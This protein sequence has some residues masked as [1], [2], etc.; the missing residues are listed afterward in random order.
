MAEVTIDHVPPR[1]RDLF[2]KGFIALERGNLDYAIELLSSCIE[3]VPCFLQ[4]R[5]FLR[6]AEIQKFKNRKGNAFLSK[7]TSGASSMPAYLS[8]VATLKAGK[9]ERA[10]EAT[11]K[12]L[13]NDPLNLKFIML[14]A[15][16]ATAAGWPEM[17]I[18]TLE[19]AKEYYPEE[20]DIVE[21]IGNLYTQADQPKEAREAFERLCELRPNNPTAIK[22]LKDAT[23]RE[24]MSK[25]G[26]GKVAEKG[27]SYRDIM[28][29]SK[30]TELLEQESKAVKSEKDIE[31]LIADTQEKLRAEPENINYFRA[32]ARLY[33]QKK[34]FTDAIATL[35]Q[36][37]KLAPGDPELD[38]A[39]AATRV[40]E[41]DDRIAHLKNA[42]DNA[43]VESKETER[44]QYIFDN[45]NDRV[46][47]YPNDL[48]LRY[49]FG[50]MLYENDY[51]NEAIQQLQMAQRSPKH[52][53]GALL[54]LGLC[55][56]QKKQYDLA[57]EQLEKAA[58]ELTMMDDVKKNILYELGEVLELMGDKEKASSYYKQ[59]YQVDIAYKDI[60]HKVERGYA[61]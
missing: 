36:A 3:T 11:E 49:E 42:G 39:M 50:V 34:A 9:A 60:A 19:I 4:A 53:V 33:V 52:R 31:S 25:D 40:A 54:H 2:N 47:R 26:W 15:E 41:F 6:A 45:L 29:D 35:D 10:V 28:K 43:G 7:L 55:L 37:L 23:A 44:Q 46:K 58:A 30:E 57:V 32:L 27:G 20:A 22:A 8:A 1:I 51:L 18:Q 24:S 5:R 38:G 13:R 14:F 17:A 16:A 59:V 56:R 21:W 61:K 48:K 12:L